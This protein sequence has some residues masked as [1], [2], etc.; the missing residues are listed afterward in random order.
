MFTVYYTVIQLII[1]NIDSI[2][3]VLLSSDHDKAVDELYDVFDGAFLYERLKSVASET[4]TVED[5]DNLTSVMIAEAL[6]QKQREIENQTDIKNS[7]RAENS[8]RQLLSQRRTIWK[9]RITI[10]LI[11]RQRRG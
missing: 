2:E 11:C 3:G 6:A 8:Q 4:D 9:N 1:N 10:I 7:V 5:Y